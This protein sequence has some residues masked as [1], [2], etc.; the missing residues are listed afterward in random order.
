[1]VTIVKRMGYDPETRVATLIFHATGDGLRNVNNVNGT[2]GDDRIRGGDGTNW[3]QGLGG[4]DVIVGG[5]GADRL[6][7]NAGADRLFGGAGD[8]KLFGHW[9]NDWISGGAGADIMDGG[10]GRD[11]LDYSQALEGVKIDLEFDHARGGAQGDRF[12]N[13][14]NAF[15]SRFDDEIYGAA[16]GSL[17][18]GGVG[19]DQLFGY[20]DYNVQ[21]DD[22]LTGDAGNDLLLGFGGSDRLYGGDGDDILSGGFAEFDEV[23]R[24]F[25]GAGDDHVISGNYRDELDGG[26]GQDHV[27]LLWEYIGGGSLEFTLLPPDQVS[28]AQWSDGHRITVTGFETVSVRSFAGSSVGRVTGGAG[29]DEIMAGSAGTHLLNGGGG[30]DTLVFEQYDRLASYV[31]DLGQTGIQRVGDS[32]LALTSIENFYATTWLPE[33]YDDQ[34]AYFVVT[35]SDTDNRITLHYQLGG[36]LYG[37]G[38][39]DVLVSIKGLDDIMDGGDGDDRIQG[40]EGADRMI[41]GLGS[42][43]LVYLDSGGHYHERWGVDIDL[44][45]G[46]GLD[47]KPT[48]DYGLSTAYGDTFE[49]FENVLGGKF[50]DALAGDGAA[51]RLIGHDGDDILTGRDG[52]DRLEGQRGADKLEGGGGADVFVYS[53]A[54]DTTYYSPGRDT[55]LDF[56]SADGDR[57]DLS[58]MDA[59]ATMA[60]DQAFVFLGYALFTGRAGELR[61]NSGHVL[62]DLDGDAVADFAIAV[63]GARYLKAGDFFL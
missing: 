4:D 40:G 59:D 3:I 30:S 23:N 53:D 21:A 9:G 29:D 54:L 15:G 28:I 26:E 1:M 36:R 27:S 37:E 52:D 5:S 57:I 46:T 25:G 11:T 63:N 13:F 50:A 34:R 56:S 35:G 39:N 47:W 6:S 16:E 17:L 58:A 60:G 49:G 48:T 2:V 14:E 33:S 7:G 44:E 31:I 38:G 61:V 8:D 41:G 18:R 43:T 62:G 51:N 24:L 32:E 20:G 19:D 45:R 42:D 55:I 12:Q 22:V 10:T